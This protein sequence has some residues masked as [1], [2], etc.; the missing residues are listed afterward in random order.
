MKIKILKV[1][2]ACLLLNTALTA[3][4]YDLLGIKRVS[5]NNLQPI[6]ENQEVKGYYSIVGIDKAG[7]KLRNYNLSILDNNL[8]KNYSVDLVKS[9][10]LSMLESSYNGERFCFSYYDARER[11]LE[12]DVLDKTGVSVGQYTIQISKSEAQLY[13]QMLK[14]EDDTYQGTLVGVKGKGFIRFGY[15]KEDGYRIAMEMIDNQGKKKWESDSKVAS[16]KSYESIFPLFTDDRVSIA[17]LTT[18]EKLMTTKGTKI[19]VVFINTDTGA[20]YF[21]LDKDSKEGNQLYALGASFDKTSQTYF[22]Y[23]QYF[24]AGDDLTKDDSKGFYM[25]EIDLSGKVISE[26][27]TTWEDR[28]FPTIFKKAKGEIKK[29]MKLYVH[30]VVRNAEGKCLLL[31][32]N[33]ARQLAV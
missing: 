33:T 30:T 13:A 15:E 19:S 24:V 21:R 2:A 14:T 32:S 1:A 28:I 29:N 10:R 9:D 8:K 25:Q 7:K 16:K 6:T 22:V 5:I 18:R 17:L 26:S 23:G 31:Q 4:T 11:I 3:Q 12:Y 27:Y 20:E